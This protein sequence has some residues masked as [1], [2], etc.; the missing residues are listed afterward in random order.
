MQHGHIYLGTV[1]KASGAKLL[2]IIPALGND[3]DQFGPLNAVMAPTDSPY[4]KGDK[5]VVGQYGVVYEDL[6]VLGKVD[7]G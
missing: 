7:V 1:A 5:V 3:D 4:Q 2:V 6:I